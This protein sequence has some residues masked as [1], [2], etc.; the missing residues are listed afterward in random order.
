[1]KAKTVVKRIAAL[2]ALEI[3]V[4]LMVGLVARLAVGDELKSTFSVKID[5]SLITENTEYIAIFVYGYEETDIVS[6]KIEHYY[7]LY[8]GA[9]SEMNGENDMFHLNLNEQQEKTLTKGKDIDFIIAFADENDNIIRKSGDIRL[10]TIPYI[11]DVRTI[12]INSSGIQV[13]YFYNITTITV[14]AVVFTMIFYLSHI[15]KKSSEK[16]AEGS[17]NEEK[18]KQIN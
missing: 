5:N 4:V 11:R 16:A 17:E 2:A 15:S 14:A 6:P 7:C 1:M 18:S 12:E 10:E 8:K 9:V 13:K 3:V